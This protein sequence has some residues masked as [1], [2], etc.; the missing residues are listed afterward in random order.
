V[1]LLLRPFWLELEL[2]P[3]ELEP[4]E[5]EPLELEPLELEPPLLEPLPQVLHLHG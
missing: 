2:E 1:A 5:L 4:L 3:L